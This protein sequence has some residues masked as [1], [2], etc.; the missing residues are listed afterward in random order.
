MNFFLKI[1]GG[2]NGL[3]Q[4]ICIELARE[5]CKIAFCDISPPDETLEKLKEF[6]VTVKA[7]KTDVSNFKEIEKLRDDIQNDFNS[8]VDI[9]VNNAGMINNEKESTRS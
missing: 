6:D 4:K 1:S 9:L 8:S 7:Y 2:S 5:G 3:G